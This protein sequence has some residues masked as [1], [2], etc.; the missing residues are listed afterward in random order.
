MGK[1]KETVWT[2]DMG[3]MPPLVKTEGRTICQQ[4][5][6]LTEFKEEIERLR[7]SM[8]DLKYRETYFERAYMAARRTLDSKGIHMDY[9]LS[10]ADYEAE[11]KEAE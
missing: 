4:E 10:R 5:C 8:A 2:S 9:F 11:L 7:A 3:F 6:Q 1:E